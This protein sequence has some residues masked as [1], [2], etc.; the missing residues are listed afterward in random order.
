MT[1]RAVAT[2]AVGLHILAVTQRERTRTLLRRTFPRR[3]GKVT[4]VRAS[5][6][7]ADAMASDLVD[8]VIVDTSPLSEDFWHAAALARTLDPTLPDV[9]P[10]STHP[11]PVCG[12][13]ARPRWPPLRR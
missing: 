6:E 3:R 2:A 9:A 8:A 4:V 7:C 1:D 13:P 5:G 12:T 11:P 10:P